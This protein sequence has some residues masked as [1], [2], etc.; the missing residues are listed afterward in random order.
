M[1]RGTSVRWIGAATILVVALVTAMVVYAT[2]TSE[3]VSAA[4]RTRAR[5]K[6]ADVAHGRAVKTS[7]ASVN[8]AAVCL[9]RVRVPTGA[10][11]CEEWSVQVRDHHALAPQLLVATKC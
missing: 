7:C 11:P 4:D 10:H 1:G 8:S 5:A 9:V 2:A 3:S 6:A